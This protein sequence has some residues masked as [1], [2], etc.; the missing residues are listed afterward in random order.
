MLSHLR[1]TFVWQ[2]PQHIVSR[3]A[4][5]LGPHGDRAAWLYTP[6]ALPL[7]EAVRPQFVVYDVMDDLAAFAKA[8]P[9]LRELS[10]IHI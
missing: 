2:R 5:L 4:A 3:L 9:E 1:W 8:P 10:L 7:A 6:V